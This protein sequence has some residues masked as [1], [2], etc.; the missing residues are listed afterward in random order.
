[1]SF[2]LGK[3]SH[4]VIYFIEDN[5]V[6]KEMEY[7][8]FEAV[9]DGVVSE[10]E[11]AGDE[12]QAVFAKLDTRLNILSAV[13]F[14]IEFDSDGA[15][16]LG[17]NL[18]LE[19]LAE[20][21]AYGPQINGATIRLAC[22]SQCPIPWL[23]NELWE[24]ELSA[25]N[26]TLKMLAAQAK[27][28]RL[29][30]YVETSAAKVPPVVGLGAS[31]AGGADA[32]GVANN[33]VPTLTP[34]DDMSLQNATGVD[35]QRVVEALTEREEMLRANL[36]QKRKEERDQALLKQRDNMAR[37]I[38]KLRAQLVSAKNRY[39]QELD[40]LQRQQ[41]QKL[42]ALNRQIEQSNQQ[43]LALEKKNSVLIDENRTLTEQAE[44]QSAQHEENI[45]KMAEQNGFD[46]DTLRKHMRRELQAKLIEHTSELESKL[47]LKEVEAN[48]REEKIKRLQRDI[49]TL[50]S[51]EGA[52]PAG[53][54][55]H[56]AER[57]ESDGMHFLVSLPVLGPVRIP[58]SELAVYRLDATAYLASRHGLQKEVFEAWWQHAKNPVCGHKH[59]DGSVC[60]QPVKAGKPQYFE[61]GYSDRC[62]EHEG[63]DF[64]DLRQYGVS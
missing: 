19:Q 20:T 17:W 43:L 9:L 56:E 62:S 57:F 23:A 58:A 6:T 47:E 10:T 11:F 21:A 31:S 4:E 63:E 3:T 53:D 30:L 50:K 40:R 42:E 51:S 15:L 22:S 55:L 46:H 2:N 24:P 25:Q 60:G 7:G 37:G 45:A 44:L 16:K 26:N 36:R 8:E 5:K 49:A 18:P 12:C 38:K 13:F 33:G 1:M 14:L 27:Q 59:A 52:A 39:A 32:N 34:A 35:Y 41:A 29:G 28:N 61:F 54:F 64:G 48:Y